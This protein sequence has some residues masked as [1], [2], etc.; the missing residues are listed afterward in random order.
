MISKPFK[1]S[2][3]LTRIG[4]RV[5]KML[6]NAVQYVS[7]K[8]ESLYFF[9]SKDCLISVLTF[10]KKSS[11][12]RFTTLV[13]IVGVDYPS[14]S[15][16]FQLVYCLLSVEYNSRI[17][18]KIALGDHD[19]VSSITNLWPGAGWFERQVWDM[20]GILFMGNTDLR[21]IL[22]DYGFTGHPLRKDYPLLGY[23]ELRYS[24]KSGR[25]IAERVELAQEFRTYE[26]QS[27][28]VSH[29]FQTKRYTEDFF[30][31]KK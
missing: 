19:P 11:F 7:I 27:P 3:Y 1:N 2:I 13:D 9:V 17:F 28:W 12:T 8:H 25:V 6:P 20:F 26:Y 18:V 10:L 14:R 16:R 30:S 15:K 31:E 24:E 29:K 23:E 4:S 21:R 22:T 5:S